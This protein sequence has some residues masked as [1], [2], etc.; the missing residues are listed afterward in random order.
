MGKIWG[1][2]K[3]W[4]IKPIVIKYPT[5][6]IKVEPTFDKQTG[7]YID[8]VGFT[9]ENPAH[10][11]YEELTNLYT[12]LLLRLETC[13]FHP[14]IIQALN[15]SETNLGISVDKF[16]NA[17]VE[18]SKQAQQTQKNDNIIMYPSEVFGNRNQ[19]S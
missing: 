10:Y 19:Q 17:H 7:Q 13:Q 5:L 11:S 4:F 18:Q 14:Y 12:N 6:T 9:I 16:M 8:F 2:V 1:W 15:A 3:S